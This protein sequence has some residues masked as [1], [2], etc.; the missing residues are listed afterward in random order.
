MIRDL[1][2]VLIFFM[3]LL[4]V[5]LSLGRVS[6]NIYRVFTKEKEWFYLSNE[7]KKIKTFGDLHIFLTLISQKTK[8]D[9]KITI[10]LADAKS[11]PSFGLAFLISCLNKM[12]N[13]MIIYAII[14]LQL[15]IYVFVFII[16]PYEPAIHVPNVIDRLILHLAPLVM[17]AISLTFYSHTKARKIYL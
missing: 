10:I 6:Y 7:E 5:V 13:F 2:K 16:S 12:K 11:D 9:S 1:L 8:S 4:W 3:I 15:I 17:F 14:F